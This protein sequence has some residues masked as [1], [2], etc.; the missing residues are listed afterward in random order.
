[1]AKALKPEQKENI[2]SLAREAIKLIKDLRNDWFDETLDDLSAL[3]SRTEDEEYRDIIN[4]TIREVDIAYDGAGYALEPA[5]QIGG[6][7]DFLTLA[8]DV[9]TRRAISI[10]T[11]LEGSRK[12]LDRALESS[13]NAED[14]DGGFDA[15]L[16][17][18]D[19][20]KVDSVLRQISGI[21][22]QIVEKA[23]GD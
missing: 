7:P 10:M 19:V 4:D 15:P 18:E 8:P 2:T 1:M 9:V 13:A 22:D 3:L 5:H 20:I 6:S 11:T 23:N 12:Q 21:V 14:L 16:E 17:R